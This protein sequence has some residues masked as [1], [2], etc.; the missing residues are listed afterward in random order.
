V[1]AA[2]V[3]DGSNVC[4]SVALACAYSGIKL[5]IATPEEY[6]LDGATLKQTVDMGGDV[7]SYVDPVEA[8]KGADVVLTDVWSGMGDE[9]NRDLK[10]KIFPPY[11]VNAQLM[12]HAKDDAIFMH[13]LPA[14]KGQEVT[15]EVIDGP[16]SVVYDE[17]E[18][19]LYTQKAL[20]L[21]LMKGFE[22]EI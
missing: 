3:G 9:A 11:Q 10:T 22:N 4:R 20:M 7:R 13:C 19:R 5:R 2:W 12:S 14:N 8:V 21:F 15:A 17:A 1:K 16:Q 6:E 18:N